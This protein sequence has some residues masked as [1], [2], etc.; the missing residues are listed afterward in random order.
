MWFPHPEYNNANRLLAALAM[1][2]RSRFLVDIDC[3]TQTR[4]QP[5]KPSEIVRFAR[6]KLATPLA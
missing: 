5:I 1:M 3:W 6:T 4:G 2:L